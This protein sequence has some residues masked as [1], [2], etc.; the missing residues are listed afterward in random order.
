MDKLR[1][2][3]VTPSR[4]TSCCINSGQNP[5]SSNHSMAKRQTIDLDLTRHKDQSE[6]TTPSIP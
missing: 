4:S 2:A 5:Q 6:R 3:F 1:G